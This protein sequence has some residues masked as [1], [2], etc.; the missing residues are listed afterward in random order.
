MKNGLKR[1]HE[2]TMLTG[3]MGLT[4]LI[5]GCHDP[6]K[7]T[8]TE[9]TRVHKNCY[10]LHIKENTGSAVAEFYKEGWLQSREIITTPITIEITST[11]IRY[12]QNDKTKTYTLQTNPSGEA[13]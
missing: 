7:S 1:L 3:L 2:K 12:T 4:L 10:G 13:R 5:R 6:A 8:A 11:T 9:S